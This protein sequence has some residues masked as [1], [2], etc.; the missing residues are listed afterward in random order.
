[1][2]TNFSPPVRLLI[3]SD[4]NRATYP[5]LERQRYEIHRASD[6][7]QAAEAIRLL[8]PDLIL[9]EAN[10]RTRKL[11]DVCRYV[12]HTDSLGFI[13]VLALID[14]K[15]S[16]A[17]TF[18]AGADEVLVQ[19]AKEREI[20]ARIAVLL[21]IKRR[22]DSLVRQNLVLTGELEE[23]TRALEFALRESAQAAILKD[24]I[25]ANVSHE[26]RTPLLQVKS[27]VAMLAEDARAA[28]D[29][30][31]TLADHATAATARLESVVQNITQLAASAKVKSE[32]F[33]LA[34][35]VS[36]AI[37]Q[38]GRRWASSGGVERI[39]VNLED[40]PPVLGD[41]GAVAQVLHQLLDNAIKFSP[42][43]G[44]IQVIAEKQG[45]NVKV[46]VSD[47]GIGIAEDQM[48]R[49]FQAFYQV[50]SGITRR[51]PGT[52]VGLAIVKLL[53]DAMGL[54]IEVASKLDEGSTF[55]FVLTIAEPELLLA[56]PAS[57]LS[58]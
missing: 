17:T 20:L 28:N 43:G 46:T 16:I 22:V 41:R 30:V 55:S 8:L 9:I 13:P 19:P 24:S 57:A 15:T 14:G 18:G 54:R 12:K 52:G 31:S 3:V 2:Q 4:S 1:M 40:L 39:Q 23:R 33:R 5:A 35:A 49:I 21:G 44:P 53:L 36:L 6:P 10:A 45:N 32:A 50:D 34:D 48:E 37:R 29:G 26:L 11:L 38:L 7:E 47:T 51:F 25:V 58:D 42:K 27:A 56:E